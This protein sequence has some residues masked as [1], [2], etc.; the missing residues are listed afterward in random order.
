MKVQ[1]LYKDVTLENTLK[2]L[3]RCKLAFDG[4]KKVLAV[5]KSV[6]EYDKKQESLN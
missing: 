4:R 3:I 6:D 1:E 5:F 2:L